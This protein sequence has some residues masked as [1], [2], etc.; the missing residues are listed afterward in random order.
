MGFRVSLGD[1]KSCLIAGRQA[2]VFGWCINK[3]VYIYIRICRCICI[4]FARAW[5]QDLWVLGFGVRLAGFGI[6]VRLEV[7]SGG[8]RLVMSRIS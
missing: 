3:Y 7:R 4:F 6:C 5:F 8:W 2:G 1:G